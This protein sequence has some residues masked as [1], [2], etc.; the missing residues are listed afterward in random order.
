PVRSGGAVLGQGVPQWMGS[1]LNHMTSWGRADKRAL[2]VFVPGGYQ[3]IEGEV[4]RGRA[5]YVQD[6]VTR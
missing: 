3:A 2:A 1:S 6:A 4:N 5:K